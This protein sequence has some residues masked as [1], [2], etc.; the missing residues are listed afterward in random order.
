MPAKPVAIA[1]HP[2]RQHP[3]GTA[4]HRVLLVDHGRDAAQRRCEQRRDARI[5]AEARRRST[6][7]IVGSISQALSDAVAEHALPVFASEIGLRPRIVALGM[8]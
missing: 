8:T 6:G 1:R 2:R 3:V 4:H 7:L 5:A